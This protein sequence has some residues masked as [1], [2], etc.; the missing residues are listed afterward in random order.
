MDHDSGLA[1]SNG[2]LHRPGRRSRDSASSSPARRRSLGTT[3][4]LQS[5]SQPPSGR[6]LRASPLSPAAEATFASPGAA[7]TGTSVSSPVAPSHNKHLSVKIPRRDAA[8]PETKDKDAKLSKEPSDHRDQKVSSANSHAAP[9]SSPTTTDL[10][11]GIDPLSQHIFART[12]TDRSLANRL[13]TPVRPESPANDGLPRPSSDLSAKQT[14]GQVEQTKDKKKAGSFLSRLSMIGGG[15]KKRDDDIPDD[16]SEIG[17]ERRI[18]GADAMAF[19]SAINASGYIP[20]HKEPPRFVRMRAHNK[21]VREFHRLFLAQELEGTKPIAPS[22]KS[23]STSG[24]GGPIWAM[25]FSKDGRYLATGGKDRVVRIWAI[26]AT[27]GDRRAYEAN[28]SQSDTQGHNQRLSAPVFSSEPLQ[29]FTGHTSDILDLS[30]SK[31]NFLLSSSMDKT[32]KLWHM[33]RPECLCTFKHKDFVTSIAF[34]PRDDRFF[35]AGSLDATLRLWSI[36]DKSIAYSAQLSDLITAVAFSPDG[37]TSIAGCLNGVCVFYDTISLT[38]QTQVHVR[39]SRG[40]NA[41]GSKIAGITTKQ[42]TN[43][44]TGSSTVRVL[45][46]SNDSRIRIYDLKDKTLVAKLKGLE[47]ACNQIGANFSDDGKYIVC[48]S[49]DR[50]VFIW[51]ATVDDADKDDKRPCEYFEAHTDVV[52]EA[53]FAPRETRMLLQASDDPVYTLCN[54]PPVTLLSREEEEKSTVHDDSLS[55]APSFRKKPEESP[56]FIARSAH[57]DGNIIVTTD[58]TGGIK[59]FRQ[60]CAF[61]KRR[62]AQESWETTSAFSKKIGK[63]NVLGRTGSIMTR[64]SGGGHHSRRSSIVQSRRGSLVQAFAPG[65]Q[66]TPDQIN[67]W[68]QGI[69]GG[70]YHTLPRS[71]PVSVSVSTPT[72]SERSVSPSKA[73]RTPLATASLTNLASSARREV[74]TNITPTTPLSPTSSFSQPVRGRDLARADAQTVPPTPS[75]SLMSADEDEHQDNVLNLDAAGAS[76]SFWNLNRWRNMGGLRSGHVANTQSTGNLPS[77]RAASDPKTLT[78]GDAA[79]RREATTPNLPSL[80]SV[81]NMINRRGSSGDRSPMSVSPE[82]DSNNEQQPRK[83]GEGRGSPT[84]RL[85]D[86]LPGFS[87]PT[88]TITRPSED[89]GSSGGHSPGAEHSG[90]HRQLSVIRGSVDLRSGSVVSQ[91]SAELT[92]DDGGE[93]EGDEM[94]CSKCG[95]REFKSKRVGGKQRFM[96]GKCGRMVDGP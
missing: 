93:G 90:G 77:T 59:V 54:P 73:A 6:Q 34:H 29:E 88:T 21:K 40:K 91:L 18:E 81:G 82:R 80:L 92:S 36:P 13:R 1:S 14:F 96:C 32:V 95:S 4:V 33:S 57:D 85:L 12:N 74:Y 56:A 67:S 49:E 64:T 50:R 46:T 47:N 19:T 35:L 72:P 31:N 37:K 69:E 39:S 60:D 84:R 9:P 87:I 42:Y 78:T 94:E 65:Q 70:H 20:R 62:Q 15:N 68:R 8:T 86:K 3:S 66:M 25:E 24:G 17:S 53:I 16:D 44:R 58:R 7:D 76:Y 75:F 38:L 83:S 11:S 10:S 43:S 23:A 89:H 5:S 52:T 26:L 61:V 63:D 28:E 51:S 22:D 79:P 48:G 2:D 71:R 55:E 27:P 45:V 30:W 41:K